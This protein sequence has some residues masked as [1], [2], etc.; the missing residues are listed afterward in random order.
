MLEFLKHS[1]I[2]EARSHAGRLL[3]DIDC[4]QQGVDTRGTRRLHWSPFF[5]GARTFILR[6]YRNSRTMCIFSQANL[7]HP[8][9]V[10][11][12]SLLCLA[13]PRR[14]LRGC[15][16]A[17]KRASVPLRPEGRG[18]VHSQSFGTILLVQD[19]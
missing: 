19:L 4:G 18:Q 1:G 14:W 2:V 11:S 17:V 12:P 6:P 9:P 8:I 3:S 16:H 13:Q 15:V 10:R 5:F 7:V